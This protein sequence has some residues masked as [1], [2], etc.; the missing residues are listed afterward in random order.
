MGSGRVSIT[1]LLAIACLLVTPRDS[2][3]F[4]G[5]RQGFLI[6]FGGGVGRLTSSRG[7]D[8]G[9]PATG[10]Q[11]DLQLGY[12]VNDRLSVYYSG[13]QFWHKKNGLFLT[14]LF[15]MAG[16]TCRLQPSERSMSLSVGA[17]GSLI[18]ATRSGEG[19]AGAGPA[20][21]V[22]VGY[23]VAPHLQLQLDTV[24]WGVVGGGTAFDLA[25]TLM[26]LGF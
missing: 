17:G 22:G 11:T 12:G 23:S 4:D 13:K 10:A 8:L 25:L 7:R 14:D 2:G 21:F 1:C 6:G 26:V 24:A 18:A 19:V 3:A 9:L 15:P 16:V 20:A 5:K